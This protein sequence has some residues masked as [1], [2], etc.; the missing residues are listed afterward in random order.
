LINKKVTIVPFDFQ[1]IVFLESSKLV[2]VCKNN[3][4]A[5][6]SISGK[7][8]SVLYTMKLILLK[9]VWF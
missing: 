4:W 6:Y 8:M 3:K 5:F 2:A 9:A 1:E 7:P